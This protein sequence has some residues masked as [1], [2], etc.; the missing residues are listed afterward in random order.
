MKLKGPFCE[1]RNRRC[2]YCGLP[3]RRPQSQR[4]CLF[5]LQFVAFGDKLA[6]VLQRLGITEELAVRAF[7]RNCGCSRRRQAINRVGFI[8]QEKL[9]ET[10]VLIKGWLFGENA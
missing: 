3:T 5:K 6:G 10:M 7:G 2:I 1:F 9:S 4:N 8:A